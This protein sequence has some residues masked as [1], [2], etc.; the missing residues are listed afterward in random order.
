MSQA[1]ASNAIA[2]GIT[3]PVVPAKRPGEDG[4]QAP[5]CQIPNMGTFYQSVES[6]GSINTENISEHTDGNSSA[7]SG[8]EENQTE[9]T[10]SNG[11]TAPAD[12]KADGAS[13]R[14]PYICFSLQVQ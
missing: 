14:A 13:V 5:P 7:N 1:L 11:D 4:L 2:Q 3:A 6:S 9:E 8:P 12:S 10:P